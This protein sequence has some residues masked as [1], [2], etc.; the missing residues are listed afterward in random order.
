MRVDPAPVNRLSGTART[1]LAEAGPAALAALARRHR[2]PI[3]EP[4]APGSYQVTFV[5]VDRNRTLC[6]AGVFCPAL[7]DGFARLDALGEG[8]F[9]R[10]FVLP[11]GVRV[12][13]HFCPDP[14]Q[15]LT[16]AELHALARSPQARRIDYSNPH[17][18]QV[19]I[20]SLR[21]R[22]LDSVLTLPG[23]PASPA[24][25]APPDA[26]RGSVEEL[27]VDSAALGHEKQL[28]LYRP[29]HFRAGE[30]YPL[31]LLMES[32]REWRGAEVFDA[33]L[34]TGRIRPFVGVLLGG[35]R[36][37]VA[38]LRDLSGGPAFA[39]FAVDELLPR[40]SALG[41]STGDGSVAAGFSAGALAAAALCAEQPR[42]FPDL[43][44]VSGVLNL[45]ALMQVT[46]PDG[47]R[48]PM[49]DRYEQTPELPRRAYLAAGQYEETSEQ[50]VW[51][52]TQALAE[53]LR[54]R[55][56]TVR[57]DGGLTDHE[58]F[59]ARAYLVE[60]LSWL[61]PVH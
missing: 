46:R 51:S 39:R 30:P 59:S 10:T 22:I 1:V 19:H 28:Q 17:V 45:S 31:V 2:G 15:R 24:V 16:P 18:D 7:P 44:A 58:A 60:G 57:M 21:L 14:P 53:I 40:L 52:Q 13:Y 33:V 47:G 23:A 29:P 11:T 8:T 37:Y 4:A 26:P 3:I 25:P 54:R 35:G 12:K 42:V 50:P 48:A 5:L 27:V 32:N 20:P 55:G 43:L 9:A 6:G 34:A 56:T 38:W 41:V 61:L 49:L 36:H